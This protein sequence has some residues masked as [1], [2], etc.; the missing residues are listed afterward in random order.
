MPAEGF[1]HRCGHRGRVGGRG[2]GSELHTGPSQPLPDQAA[3]RDAYS[4]SAERGAEHGSQRSGAGH[5]C[6]GRH[7]D[8]GGEDAERP[9]VSRRPT[10]VRASEVTTASWGPQEVAVRAYSG[11]SRGGAPYVAV[12]VGTCPRREVA[13]LARPYAAPSPARPA[14]PQQNSGSAPPPPARSRSSHDT[15]PA[16]RPDHRPRLR[17]PG[18]RPP[19]PATAGPCQ[20]PRRRSVRPVRRAGGRSTTSST[21][22]ARAATPLTS[23]WPR[24]TP[25]ASSAR[26]ATGSPSTA[27]DRP[28]DKQRL[29]GR[30][31]SRG[32]ERACSVNS[33]RWT[34]RCTT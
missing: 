27:C 1:A 18:R 11:G 21:P 28:S 19:R 8:P 26:P 33:S 25:P 32:A 10:P 15:D 22:T 17:R 3:A 29:A 34:S 12:S 30:R 24:S 7:P 2:P 4:R 23:P 9:D 16:T 20:R 13:R 14:C 31:P 5:G 6:P